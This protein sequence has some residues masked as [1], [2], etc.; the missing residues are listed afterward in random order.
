MKELKHSKELLS[1]CIDYL[2]EIWEKEEPKEIKNHFKLIGF[3][4]NDLEYYGI[5][6]SLCYTE[7]DSKLPCERY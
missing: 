6:E 7:K 2:M 5:N 1:K 3:T 4:D